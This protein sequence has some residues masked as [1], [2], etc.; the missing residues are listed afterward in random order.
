MT[1]DVDVHNADLAMYEYLRVATSAVFV[2]PSVLSIPVA[3]FG[4]VMVVTG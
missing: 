1:G 4:S 2:L 3:V